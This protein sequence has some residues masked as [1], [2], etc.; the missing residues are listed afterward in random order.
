VVNTFKVAFKEGENG[1]RSKVIMI[2]MIAMLLIGPIHGE[3]A[4]SY[5]FTRFKFNWSEIEFSIFSTYSMALQL[6]GT[7]FAVSV[8]SRKFKVSDSVS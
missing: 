3:I 5:L 8:L 1:R 4:V 2:L 6:M 7:V